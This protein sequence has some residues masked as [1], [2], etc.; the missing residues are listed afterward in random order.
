MG[1]AEENLKNAGVRK[2]AEEDE[3][4]DAAGRLSAMIDEKKGNIKDLNDSI[5]EL[6]QLEMDVAGLRA[7]IDKY[8]KLL[9]GSRSNEGDDT[10]DRRCSSHQEAADRVNHSN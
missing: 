8:S 2:A 9:G 6:K 5:A 3:A 7:E 1:K 10:K 4:A